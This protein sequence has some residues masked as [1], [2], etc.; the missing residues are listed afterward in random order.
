MDGERE[1]RERFARR[2]EA[3]SDIVFG[4]ALAQS[5]IALEVPKSIGALS[6]QVANLVFFAVTF[7]AIAVFWSMH[8][9]VFRDAFVGE[10]IDVVV[11]FLLLAAIALLPYALRLYTAFPQSVEGSA[12]YS[13]AFGA[14]LGLLAFL[15]AR[16]LRAFAA[17]LPPQR[18]LRLRKSVHVHA[19]AAFVFLAALVLF[20][21]FG[22]NARAAWIGVPL[23]VLLIR[24]V[25]R[26]RVP[27]SR[28]TVPG[29]AES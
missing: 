18:A 27:A 17:T 10:R 12:A 22:L 19:A 16:G 7:A 23:V 11:N 8:Y 21:P 24:R 9:R 3:F 29:P 13:A 5:A 2:L 4:F 14:V 1:G 26:M 28:G 15:E 25:E 20:V 6:G